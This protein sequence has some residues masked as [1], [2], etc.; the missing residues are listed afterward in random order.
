MQSIDPVLLLVCD[1]VVVIVPLPILPVYIPPVA[2]VPVFPSSS[3]R[4]SSMSSGLM[5]HSFVLVF[6]VDVPPVD[7]VH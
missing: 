7:N 5:S 4:R 6:V 2:F 3:L 1:P